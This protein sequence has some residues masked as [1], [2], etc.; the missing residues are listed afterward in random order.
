MSKIPR[1]IR[2][3][4]ESKLP[5]LLQEDISYYSKRYDKYV[6]CVEGDESDGATG[7]FDIK[8]ASW[9]IH[10]QL[11]KT[12]MFS[13]GTLCSNLQASMIIYDILCAEGRWFRARTWMIS[14][15]AIGGGE[16]RKN[17]LFKTG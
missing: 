10:D 15:F 8:S 1:Y 7:A 11:C 12:G 2:R 14:T 9:W 5:Y 17:G 3:S 4:Y 6:H 13:D 16:A